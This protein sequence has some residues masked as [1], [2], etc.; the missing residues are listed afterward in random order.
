MKRI[1]HIIIALLTIGSSQLAAQKNPGN[2]IR[3]IGRR[4]PTGGGGGGGGGSSD[5]LVN[6]SRYEDSITIN[7]Y[8]ADSPRPYK[9][10]SS[11][12][13]YYRR[14]PIPPTHVYLGNNGSPTRS[15]L[16]APSLNI[17]FDPGFHALDVY[18]IPLAKVR[19]FNVTRPYTELSYSLASRAEQMIELFHTQNIR[20]Y[21]NFSLNYK[22]VNAPG[23]F[24]NQ[25]TNHN[26]YVFSSWYQSPSKRYNN[27]FVILGNKLQAGEN[28]GILDDHD[29]LNDVVFAKD[30]FVIPTKIGGSPAYATDFFS[31]GITT[32]NRYNEFNIVL[33]QQ[34]D[35]GRKDSI[36]TDTTVIP[37][38][39]PRLRF[40]HSFKYGTYR[41]N[42][43]DEIGTGRQ[44]N[45][46]DSQYYK[47]TYDLNLPTS[48]SIYFRD[49]WK[50]I[51]N[52]FSVY[53]FPDAKNLQQFIKL[54]MELQLLSGKFF[55][56][57][58]D[59]PG[60]SFHNTIAH[61][62]YRNRTR[63]QLWDIMAQGRLYLTGNNFGDYK[64][65]VSLQRLLSKRFGSFQA[66]FENV[67][68][69]APFIY[70]QRSAFYLDAPKSFNKENT[71]H[72]FA[73]LILPRLGMQ[74]NGDYYLVSNYLY[75]D[76][77]RRLQQE[78]TIFNVL[79]ISAS[80][81][82]R[83]SRRFSLYT[84]VYVQKKTGSVDLNLPLVFMRH[85][86]MYEGNLG[87][88]NLN[89]AF[90]LDARYHSPYKADNY[91]PVLGQFFYQDSVTISN[92]P[93]I[94]GFLHFRIR[95]FKLYLRAENLNTARL[96]GGFQFNNNNL[97]APQ[98]PT[99]GLVLRLGIYWSFVN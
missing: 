51:S 81:K 89:I 29:Y 75:L 88:P 9:I 54:G 48:G 17:G 52:D 60:T 6:R 53:Q 49:H 19:F 24:R 8:Y 82:F 71:S 87:F 37:L 50:E 31:N 70:D 14:F 72:F 4:I 56:D 74:L 21:W 91:S 38:F 33:R 26:S 97:A 36:V 47:D 43:Q 40:E 25:K 12:Q 55:K 77:Y 80:K 16:Y 63:N 90:G 7:V 64:A 65:Y 73:S 62:E 78:G 98:Y 85:R 84:D 57:S 61:A 20:P 95:S 5:S 22:L 27:Y 34:Y 86:I 32:G 45:V 69:S 2:V 66:G 79:R 15:I 30:R 92:L 99:P 67:N 42:Y 35:F 46:P 11:I 76:G 3:D 1:V 94:A 10:D 68:R 83:I 18:K 13:D 59:L 93:D 23:I 44:S 96:F 58:V 28:G 41:Y 39:Y